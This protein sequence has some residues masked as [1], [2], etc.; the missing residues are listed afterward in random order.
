MGSCRHSKT[1]VNRQETKSVQPTLNQLISDSLINDF[2]SFKI[3]LIKE[4]D[5]TKTFLINYAEFNCDKNDSMSIVMLDSLSNQNIFNPSDLPFVFEQIILSKTYLYEQ[6]IFRNTI[7]IPL[8]TIKKLG[9]S[10]DF[11]ANY[12]QKYSDSRGFWRLSVP[13]FSIDKQTV[14]QDE[15]FSCGGLCG[16]GGT[17]IYRKI[18]KSWKLIYGYNF[19]VS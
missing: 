17:Y 13:I 4:N 10:D 15:R 11:W 7:L 5:T 6:D 14:I 2:M 3:A 18:N 12:R 1:E 9:E 8:D 19:R 16:G